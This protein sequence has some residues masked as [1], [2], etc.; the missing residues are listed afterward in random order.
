[1]PIESLDLGA[2]PESDPALEVARALAA[3]L[4]LDDT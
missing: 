3:Y 1:L 2:C 4:G